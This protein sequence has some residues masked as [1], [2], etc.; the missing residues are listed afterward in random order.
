MVALGLKQTLCLRH[1]FGGGESKAYADPA[2][3]PFGLGKSSPRD[4]VRLLEMLEKGEVVSKEASAEMIGILRRQQYKNGIARGLPDSVDSA[5]K[6]GTLDALRADVGILY[7]PR[8]RIAIAITVDEMPAVIYNEE[9]PGLAMI[10][11]LS[12]ILQDGL[13]SGTSDSGYKPAAGFVPDE[14]TAIAIALAA[15][16][17]IYGKKQIDSEKPYNAV[18]KDG[19]WTV[20]GS[21]PKGWV[22]G[23]AEALISRD[24]GRILKI[25]HY[26]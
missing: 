13:G 18:L 24:D 2:N 5:S 17:P 11:K 25:I 12:Q 19:I 3:K 4:M 15:W 21:L 26:K 10:W 22:G 8:G 6:S 23:T 20:T 7:T 16:I 1:V 14:K 9:N